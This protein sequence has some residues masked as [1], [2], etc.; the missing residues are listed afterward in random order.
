MSVRTQHLTLQRV[1]W[2]GL[3]WLLAKTA[4]TQQKIWLQVLTVTSHYNYLQPSGSTELSL[5]S[6]CLYPGD[7]P[8][9]RDT[10]QDYLLRLRAPWS[11]TRRPWAGVIFCV[12]VT[13]E[14][15]LVKFSWKLSSKLTT[16]PC[17]LFKYFTYL[18]LLT[19]TS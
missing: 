6:I 14:V 11:D 13:L 9:N 3:C 2:L 16:N 4:W 10:S 5:C 12:H 7:L 19:K 17:V 18:N 1:V 15:H 8:S